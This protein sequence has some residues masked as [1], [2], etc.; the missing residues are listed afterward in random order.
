MYSITYSPFMAQKIKAPNYHSPNS[1]FSRLGRLL[2][3]PWEHCLIPQFRRDN[4]EKNGKIPKKLV[5]FGRTIALTKAAMARHV[6][7]LFAAETK[8]LKPHGWGSWGIL[9][10]PDPGQPLK[11][12]KD[13]LRCSY[14]PFPWLLCCWADPSRSSSGTKKHL[15]KPLFATTSPLTVA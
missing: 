3:E 2:F 4:L 12:F 13:H 1:T 14:Y 9:R 8:V 5:V 6:L 10:Y 15:S 7:L 11:T